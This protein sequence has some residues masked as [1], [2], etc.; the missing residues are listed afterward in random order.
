MGVLIMALEQGINK[1]YDQGIYVNDTYDALYDYKVFHKDTDHDTYIIF[2]D[3]RKRI[4]HG[5]TILPDDSMNLS[6]TI[7]AFLDKQ[8]I[9]LHNA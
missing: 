1:P 4:T 3:L 7:E 2:I 6:K 5:P 9:R 8:A